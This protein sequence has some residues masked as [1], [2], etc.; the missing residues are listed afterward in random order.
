[1]LGTMVDDIFDSKTGAFVP[2]E[3]VNWINSNQKTINKFPKF[4]DTMLLH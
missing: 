1:M 2:S 4:E 3:I